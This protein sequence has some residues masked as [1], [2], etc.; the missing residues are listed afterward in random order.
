MIEPFRD[1]NESFWPR[2]YVFWRDYFRG[3][4]DE[5]RDFGLQPVAATGDFPQEAFLKTCLVLS[6][7][8]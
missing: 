6:E 8:T 2:L 3:G 4:I 5:L 1:V 7:K